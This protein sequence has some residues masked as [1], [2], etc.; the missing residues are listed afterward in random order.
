MSRIDE[1]W[2]YGRSLLGLLATITIAASS[3][4]AVAA[5]TLCKADELVVFSCPTGAHVASICASK[6]ISNSE[7]YM[8]YRYGRKDSLDLAY[9]DVG[10]KPVDVFTSGILMFSAGGGAWL[11]FS[12][13]P[14]RY[15][16]FTA[17]GKWGP[18]G[19]H[20]TA[21]GVAVEKDGK[22]FA[23]FPC[24]ATETSELGPD[25]FGKLGLNEAKPDEE[26]EIP[27]AFFPK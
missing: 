15:T 14:F 11:R 4:P 26:F 16:V 1:R 2:A 7:G 6:N 22:E 27:E 5:P 25:F 18:A 20:A 12:K 9:P 23:N 19:R 17:I 8:Q 3:Y 24:R 21:A 13:G 10:A